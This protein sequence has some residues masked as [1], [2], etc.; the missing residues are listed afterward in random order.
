ML[1]RLLIQCVRNESTMIPNRLLK[2]AKTP[3]KIK[4][5]EDIPDDLPRVS[6]QP[7]SP[8]FEVRDG[9]QLV[10]PYSKLTYSNVNRLKKKKPMTVM[11]LLETSFIGRNM[12][13]YEKQIMDEQLWIL[14]PRGKP[15]SLGKK[16]LRNV[17]YSNYETLK[18]PD[19]FELQLKENDVVVNHACVHELKIP[20]HPDLDIIY[21]NKQVLV[22]N[23]PAGIPVHP[24]GSSYRF[25]TLQFLLTAK[26]HQ[27]SDVH[28]LLDK[29][30]LEFQTKLWPCHRLDKDTSGVL[31]FAK[32]QNKCV[33][34]SKQIES[35]KGMTKRYLAL[36]HGK[37]GPKQRIVKDPVVEVDLAKRYENGGIGKK[38]LYGKTT[39]K[40]IHYDEKSDTSLLDCHLFTGRR[41]QIRQH[42]RNLGFHIVNDPL[43]GING[44]LKNKMYH[45]PEKAEFLKLRREYELQLQDRTKNWTKESICSNCYHVTYI[46]PT[47]HLDQYMRLHSIEYT[48]HP[49]E[50]VEPMWEFRTGLPQWAKSILPAKKAAE[51]NQPVH[52]NEDA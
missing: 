6:P 20:H 25:N 5:L 45:F 9:Y 12:K 4:D 22:V 17:D 49:K 1:K 13:F 2:V 32:N 37:F 43:Y 24:S 23:K 33:E 41:H 48:Y 39:F 51:F 11:K 10:S 52:E 35:K 38:I 40:M 29:E 3:R 28:V 36:V 16:K 42:L 46:E 34:I 7:N 30:T 8:I 18:G 27:V 26:M 19:L 50:S 15:L 47:N 14:R 31:I 44:I 21:E